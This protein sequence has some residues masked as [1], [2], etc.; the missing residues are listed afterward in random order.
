MGAA[1]DPHLLRECVTQSL[2]AVEG[3]VVTKWLIF[4][5]V[6]MAVLTLAYLLDS[7]ESD[8]CDHCE[9]WFGE[10][11]PCCWCGKAPKDEE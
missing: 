9:H 10:G 11:K 2:A 4:A 1:G 5:A 8:G 6:S 7:L 3:N